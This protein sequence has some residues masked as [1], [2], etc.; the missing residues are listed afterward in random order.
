MTDT[1]V[2]PNVGLHFDLPE[3]EY[4]THPTSLSVS[5][6]KVLLRS[7]ALFKYEREHPKTKAVWE[8]GTAAHAV[9]VGRGRENV[10]VVDA[11]SW[12]TK[13]AQEA[14]DAARAKGL[15]PVLAADWQ[16]CED[17]GAVLAGNPLIRTLLEGGEPEVSAFVVDEP[18]G[19]LRRA[20]FDYLHDDGLIVDYKSAASAEPGAFATAAARYGYHQQAA[21]YLDV[22]ADLAIRARAFVFV[23]QEKDPPYA[24]AVYELDAA[25]VD[26]GRE[27]NRAALER[28]RDCTAVDLWPGYPAE[29]EIHRLSLPRWAYRTENLL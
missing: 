26:L 10:V 11:D 18:T 23:V 16:T 5:G 20:R 21:W 7:P 1:Y 17:M 27:L 28:F 12:R 24:A 22:L 3:A 8:V 2:G 15:A 13:A 29:T 9:A 14:R 19:V 25:D 4:H 6:A